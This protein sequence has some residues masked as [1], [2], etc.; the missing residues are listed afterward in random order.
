MNTQGAMHQHDEEEEEQVQKGAE[1]IDLAKERERREGDHEVE[2]IEE[3]TEAFCLSVE[4]AVD[5]EARK[6]AR[7][8]IMKKLEKAAGSEGRVQFLSKVMDWGCLDAVIGAIF[9]EVGDAA[10][11]A[12]EITYLLAEAERADMSLK[13]EAK[14]AFYQLVDLGIGLIPVLGDA[15]DLMFMANRMSAEEFEKNL[16]GKAEEAIAAGVPKEQVM[17]VLAK[18]KK[19][20][21]RLVM[22]DKVVGKVSGKAA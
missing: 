21:Q 6:K 1:V 8:M 2:D 20:Q 19:L 9:P 13:G 12:V 5:E 14:I 16:Q 11:S 18:N 7:A 15:G 17:D 22:A 10:A 4:G 3:D